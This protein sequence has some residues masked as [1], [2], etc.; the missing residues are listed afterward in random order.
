[1]I[2]SVSQNES[3]FEVHDLLRSRE[4][5]QRS[6][7]KRLTNRDQNGLS[8]IAEKFEASPEVILQELV[9]LTVDYCGADASGISLEE[10]DGKGGLHF[11]WIAVA[12]S[13]TKYLNGT[14]PRNYS[15]CGSCLDQGKP[16]LFRVMKPYYDFL[17]VTAEP[18]LDGI[19]IPWDSGN[20]RGTIWAV[21]HKSDSAFDVND[22][23]TIQRLADL[24][25]IAL[26]HQVHQ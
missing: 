23:A 18:I 25:S 6:P 4:F 2:V 7:S 10:P 26:R 3:G 20:M 14:T 1:M 19:L 9:E 12:G 5:M 8:R 17:G 13:F 21:S 24:V 16:Q 22:Y 15:P 11:R